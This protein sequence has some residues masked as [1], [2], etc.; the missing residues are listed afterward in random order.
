MTK[1][2]IKERVDHYID[3]VGLRGFENHFPYQLS[4]GMQQRAGLAR[5]LA[6]HPTSS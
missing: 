3:M 1:A 2:E 5:A 4:G 6:I